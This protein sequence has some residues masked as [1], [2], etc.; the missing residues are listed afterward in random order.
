MMLLLLRGRGALAKVFAFSNCRS[1]GKF[2]FAVLNTNHL[3]IGAEAAACLMQQMITVQNREITE[4]GTCI[5]R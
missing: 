1:T 5:N 4:M 2:W 3:S